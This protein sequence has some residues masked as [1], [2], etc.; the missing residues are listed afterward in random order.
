MSQAFIRE[1][2][3]QWLSD[4]APTLPALIVY[5][6]R[7]NNGIRVYESKNSTD[8]DG[9]EIHVMSNGLSYAKDADGKWEIV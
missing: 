5:L 2:D 4:V 9:R 3:D 7:N 8:Q 6:T 1:S